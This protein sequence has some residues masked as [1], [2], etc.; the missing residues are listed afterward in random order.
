MQKKRITFY[1]ESTATG[2]ICLGGE[3][4]KISTFL[5][6]HLSDILEHIGNIV[7]NGLICCEKDDEADLLC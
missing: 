6:L 3:I 4:S 1:R 2:I 7:Q 5:G